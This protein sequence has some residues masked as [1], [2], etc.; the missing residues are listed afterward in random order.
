VD[1]LETT[2]LAYLPLYQRT[3]TGIVV[4]RGIAHLWSGVISTERQFLVERYR[5]VATHTVLVESEASGAEKGDGAKWNC[6]WPR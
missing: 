4:D 6:A 3:G 2:S 5:V 1:D